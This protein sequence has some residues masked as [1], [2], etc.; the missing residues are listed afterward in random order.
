MEMVTEL[1]IVTITIMTITLV[2]ATTHATDQDIVATATTTVAV[3]DQ[4]V[5]AIRAETIMFS[6]ASIF[7]QTKFS[8]TESQEPLHGKWRGSFTRQQKCSIYQACLG[9]NS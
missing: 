8:R 4:T 9:Q 2:D 7:S 3:S 6:S 5:F 1:V